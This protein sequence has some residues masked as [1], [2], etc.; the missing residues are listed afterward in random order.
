[1]EIIKII[2]Q[3]SSGYGPADEAYKDKLILTSCSISYEY[4]PHEK[5]R[6]QS[7]VCRKWSYKT[8]SPV[9]KQIFRKAAEKTPDSLN[10][11]KIPF[12]IDL[13]SIEITAVFE[14]KHREKAKFFCSGDCFREYFSVIKKLVPQ[15]EYLPA[16]LLTSDDFEGEDECS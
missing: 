4:K 13:G 3:G 6:S 10:S 11:N 15:T 14:D 9:F 2:I 12:V 7:N 16:V 1:M 5:S 8:T